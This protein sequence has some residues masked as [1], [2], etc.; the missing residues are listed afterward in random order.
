MGQVEACKFRLLG[1]VDVQCFQDPVVEF[2]VVDEFKRAEGMGDALDGIAQRMGVI[3]ERVD[4][5][6]IACP[7]VAGMA[8]A[9]QGR[10]AHGHIG[11]GHVDLGTKHL[12]PV[13][14][15]AG[16]HA[17]E[18]I[19]VFLYRAVAAGAFL[20]RFRKGAAVFAYLVGRKVVHIGLAPADEFFCIVVELLE[21]VG[22]VEFAI[23]P[24]PAKPADVFLDG[25]NVFDVFLGGVGIVKAEVAQAVE[26]LC[27]PEIETDRLCVPKVQ[28]PVGFRG[29]TCVHLAAK[30]HAGIVSQNFGADKINAFFVFGF[31]GHDI[32]LLLNSVEKQANTPLLVFRQICISP[33]PD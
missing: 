31:L 30:T 25:V 5:P 18:E 32:P 11:R 17:A 8:D 1:M 2:P 27:Y 16:A 29:E 24:V 14:E 22:S 21:V 6:G 7:V 12:F 19:Q 4:A 20:A 28:I 33:L 23:F 26:F 9:V 10:I 13:L 3:V 15:F